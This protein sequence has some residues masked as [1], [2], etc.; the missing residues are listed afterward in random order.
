[1]DKVLNGIGRR[2][3]LGT[4]SAAGAT[5]LAGCVDLGDSDFSKED[6]LAEAAVSL[7]MVEPSD[8]TEDL[9]P[10]AD[11]F[12]GASVIAMGEATHGTREFS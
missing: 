12:A 7:E 8:S 10:L 9:Q 11:V 1:M 3:S 4:A 2:R 5:A 6:L